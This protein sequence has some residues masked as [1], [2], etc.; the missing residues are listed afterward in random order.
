MNK[1][2]FIMY[3]VIVSIVALLVGCWIGCSITPGS[4]VKTETE[5]ITEPCDHV[6]LDE[7]GLL[8]QSS[9]RHCNEC[10]IPTQRILYDPQNNITYIYTF[11]WKNND[12]YYHNLYL[13]NTEV[14]KV[15][16]DGTSVVLKR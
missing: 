2:I 15:W 4:I 7:V 13:N 6:D 11:F 14:L 10:D 9:L 8:E 3:I 1:S 5:I 12:G 16:G